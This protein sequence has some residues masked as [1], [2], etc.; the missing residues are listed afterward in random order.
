M[1]LFYA[2]LVLL[3]L[4]VIDSIQIRTKLLDLKELVT[5]AYDQSST[6][7]AQID[8]HNMRVRSLE[9]TVEYILSENHIETV[10]FEER[11]DFFLGD[12]GGT[13]IESLYDNQLEPFTERN[14]DVG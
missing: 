1:F 6:F 13:T 5:R 12:P 11:R 2:V 7:S 3:V 10:Q 14:R 9:N 4:V 8:S